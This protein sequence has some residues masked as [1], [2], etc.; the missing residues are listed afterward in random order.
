MSESMTLPRSRTLVRF[1]LAGV[2]LLSVA[3]V[4]ASYARAAT[5]G[6]GVHPPAPP[7]D[8]ATVITDQTGHLQVYAP[9]GSVVYDDHRYL[10]YWD[11]DPVPGRERTLL[12]VATADAAQSSCDGK[13][14][15]RNIV[16]LLNLTT[17]ERTPLFSRVVT[18]QGSNEW[19]DAD[20]VNAS[21]IAVADIKH[22]RV[23]VADT[24][25]DRITWAWN[26]SEHFPPTSGGPPADWTHINDVEVLPDGRVMAS[27]RNQDQIVFVE[28][29]KGVQK[30]WTLGSEGNH[31]MLFGQHNPD[32]IPAS[33][34]GPAV[35]VA[36]SH[37]NRVIEFQRQNG[38]WR[39]TWVWRDYRMQWTRDADRLPNG[40]TLIV[41]TNGDRVL[42]VDQTGD[43]VWSVPSS[44]PY[45][46]ERLGTGD[47]STGG[48][49]AT[50]AN[51]SSHAGP[52]SSGGILVVVSEQLNDALPAFAFNSLLY[53]LPRWMTPV[54]LTLVWIALGTLL[55][56]SGAEIWWRRD[57]LR[58][59]AGRLRQRVDQRR[60]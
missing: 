53:V 7:R 9:N 43:V 6:E 27:I 55:V 56:W 32:Y 18:T 15:E 16:G 17:R 41:D 33:K 47:E 1:A 14:C 36:D 45:D 24:R 40:H 23:F 50:A 3:P 60:V 26:A 11:I 31:R 21:H 20:R 38:T 57:S 46:V 42:E 4:T 5:D 54:D 37:N 13:S 8:R 51:L 59:T 28:P 25:T 58:A 49:S 2:V 34:G 39:H 22:D 30:S 44:K 29:G 12:Y 52:S 48:P 19:H 35:V 10:R